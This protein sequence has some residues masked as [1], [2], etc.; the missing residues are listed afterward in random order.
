M[1]LYNSFQRPNS[2]DKE[3]CLHGTKSDKKTMMLTVGCS[4]TYYQLMKYNQ[5]IFFQH[6][7][8]GSISFN[9]A[10]FKTI[11]LKSAVADLWFTTDNKFH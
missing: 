10:K 6:E 7:M 3:T 2:K 11:M 1:L 9:F 5:V 8:W 4:V